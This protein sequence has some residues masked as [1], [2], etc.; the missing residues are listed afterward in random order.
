LILVQQLASKVIADVLA[1]HNLDRALRKTWAQYSAALA[2]GERGAIQDISF[3]ALR[4]YGELKAIVA[5]LVTRPLQEPGIFALLIVTLFQL[6]HSKAAPH[7][8]VDHAVQTSIAL[9]KPHLKGFVNAVL[10]NYLRQSDTLSVA[11]LGDI[12]A[13]LSYPTWWIEKVKAQYPAQW[14]A[15]LIA[16]N[17][18]PPMTLRVNRR[19]SDVQSYLQRLADVEIA[20][21]LGDFG[22]VVLE[23]PIGIERLPGFADGLVS[24]QDQGAQY[25]AHLLDL[26]PGQRVLDACAAPGGKTGHILELADVELTAIDKDAERLSQVSDNLSRLQLSASIKAADATKRD[27]WWDHR[28]FDRI[29]CDAPCTASGVVKRHPDIKWLRRAADVASFAQQ[30]AQLLAVLWTTLNSGGKLLYATCSIFEEENQGQVVDFC[31]HHS[32]AVLL[33][34]SH[35][36][37]EGL[38]LLPNPRADGFFY[39]LLQKQ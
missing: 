38:Q 34:L 11:I 9:G 22:A 7:A 33:H 21:A 28:P 26:A 2:P 12:E 36:G 3:G 6:R 10:R 23:H 13:R 14:E 16:G 15:I 4:C 20:A 37:P 35:V 32:D 31:R 25:A 24:V 5:Q 17:Q 8:I 1:G 27:N 29:L 39:A 18:H 30:Q 19:K